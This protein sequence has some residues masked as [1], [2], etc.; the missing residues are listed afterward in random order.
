MFIDNN[1]E[2]PRSTSSHESEVSNGENYSD[3]SS[4]GYSSS[5]PSASALYPVQH[6]PPRLR[7]HAVDFNDGKGKFFEYLGLNIFG[8]KLEKNIGVRPK[9]KNYSRFEAIDFTS[10]LGQ[11][12]IETSEISI[13]GVVNNYTSEIPVPE[14][15]GL[16]SETANNVYDTDKQEE[17]IVTFKKDRSKAAR[18]SPHYISFNKRQRNM[19]LQIIERGKLR[20]TTYSN[21]RFTRNIIVYML[22]NCRY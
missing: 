6:T 11:L 20:S 19:R 21:A 1:F 9:A 13:N 22:Y 3:E 5:A 7:M 18:R 10:P 16:R 14:R 15:K 2:S 12:I 4:S 8:K 17:Y